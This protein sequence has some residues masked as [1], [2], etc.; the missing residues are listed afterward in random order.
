MISRR[1]LVAS[2]PL[3]ALAMLGACAGKSADQTIATVAADANTIAGGLKGVL[4]QLGP[5]NVPGLTPSVISTV[6]VA[7]SEIQTV[8]ASLSGVTS[9]AAAQPLVQK[10]ETYLNTIVAALAGLPLPPPI[11]TALQA[12]AILL[13]I[14]EAAVGL[15]V[16]QAAKAAPGAISPDQARMI[17]RGS[18]ATLARP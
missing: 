3:A 13:P 15:V 10:I 18:A 11:S 5:L 1:S 17:L 12:A 6:G 4:A 2:T 16:Q 14:I 7:V 9:A 8:A